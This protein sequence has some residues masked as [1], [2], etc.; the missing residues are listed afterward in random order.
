MADGHGLASY[1]EEARLTCYYNDT[2]RELEQRARK[3][4][5]NGFDPFKKNH[6][7]TTSS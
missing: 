7:A 4:L 2:I 6:R 3:R 5:D 1:E